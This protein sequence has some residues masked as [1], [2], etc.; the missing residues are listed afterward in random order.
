MYRQKSL[1]RRL[2]PWLI[3]AIAL[4][5]LVIF[6]FVPIYSQKEDTNTN[7]PVISYYEGDETPLVMENDDLVFTMDPT[8]TRFQIVEKASGRTWDSTDGQQGGP[9]RDDAGR[10]YDKQ[11]RNHHEQ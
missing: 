4:A 5:C 11:R 2:I 9:F 6:V 3:V 10:L 8:T 1:I 7:P